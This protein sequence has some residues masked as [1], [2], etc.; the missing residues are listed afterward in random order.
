METKLKCKVVMLPTEKA[1][2]L[3]KHKD[4]GLM[5]LA[6]LKHEINC[7]NGS[8]QHLYFTSDREIS[9]GDLSLW[10]SEIV[11]ATS[12]LLTVGQRI[13]A[14]T[15]PTLEL[16]LIPQSFIEKFVEKQGEIKEVMVEMCDRALYDSPHV[17]GISV[18]K[19]HTVICSPVKDT[20]TR[21]EVEELFLQFVKDCD[22]ND[23]L[24]CHY[25]GDYR[26][27]KTW[28]KTNL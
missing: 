3:Y 8:N 19:D 17:T 15:D 12:S 6:P 24:I 28:L 23:D 22:P 7:Y 25:D 18:R 13:E 10:K 26:D 21:E 11:R 4:K 5:L 20:W 27:L 14:T 2:N 1:V 9:V 16:P